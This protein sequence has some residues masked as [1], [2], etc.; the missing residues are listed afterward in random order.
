LKNEPSKELI[1]RTLASEGFQGRAIIFENRYKYIRSYEPTQ[2]R[3]H[4]PQSYLSEQTLYF[5]REQLYDLK[6]DPSEDRNLVSTDLDLL[7]KARSLYKSV[8]KVKDGW[9]LVIE[10]PVAAEITGR[11]PA[12]TM[13]QL[14]QGEASFSRKNDFVY[15]HGRDQTTIIMQITNWDPKASW[16]RVG[17]RK[18]AVKRTSLRL[19]LNTDIASLP[20]ESAGQESLIPFPKE[21]TAYIRRVEDSGREERKIRITNPAFESVLREWGYLNDR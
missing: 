6:E 9:E 1:S 16:I 20:I 21:P 19:P 17:D 7:E 5:S 11:F 3:V 2:K 8:F 13:I 18:V 4:F 10:S 15:L 12:S 14:S